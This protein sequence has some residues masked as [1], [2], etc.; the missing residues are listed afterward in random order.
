MKSGEIYEVIIPEENKDITI[1]AVVIMVYGNRILFYGKNTLFTM[2][3]SPLEYVLSDDQ[4]TGSFIA[5]ER[6]FFDNII[7]DDVIIKSADIHLI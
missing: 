3:Y 5:S 4:N 7:V 2:I 6:L 1:K